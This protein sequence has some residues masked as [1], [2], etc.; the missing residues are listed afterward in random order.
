MAEDNF[1][2]LIYAFI[3]FLLFAV[4]IITVVNE[5]GA[6]YGKDVSQVTGGSLN[7]DQFNNSMSDISNNV[8][9]YR[10]R[11]FE[12]NIFVA[13]GDVIFTGVFEIG[14]DM[15]DI[16]LTPFALMSGIMVNT[17][18]IPKFVTDI[19]MALIGLAIIF[20]VWR[21]IKIGD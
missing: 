4:L 11:F 15:V 10:Q 5:Q 3:F 17:L 1:K 20:G 21:L 9:R 18:K 12:G 2:N 13:L 8:E 14:R 16:I 7:V 19:I 6:V